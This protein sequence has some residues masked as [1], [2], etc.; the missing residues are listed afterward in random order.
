MVRTARKCREYPAVLTVQKK[1]MLEIDGRIFTVKTQ[2][3]T[4]DGDI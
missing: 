1:T 2:E 4:F 3:I